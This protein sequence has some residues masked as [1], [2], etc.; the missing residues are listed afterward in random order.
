MKER[1]A[2]CNRVRGLLAEYGL[3]L[4]KGV[5]VLRRHLPVFLEDA[6]NGLNEL[7][8]RLL[9]EG[10]QQ[11]QDLDRHIDSYTQELER[12]AQQYDECR[13]LQTIPGY[14]PIVASAFH[15]AIGNGEAY[16]R[17]RDV[18]ASLGLVPRQHS[19]GGKDVLL[20]ISKRGDR[21]LRSLLVHGARSVVIQAGKKD[22]RLS[23]WINKIRAKRGFNRAVVALANK[24]ARIGWAVLAH[25]TVYQAA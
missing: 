11:L 17:G 18:S 7:F 16:R 2:L 9:A 15:S 1:T 20:G 4:P 19:S 6:E 25:K 10:Y 23:R 13:R 24:M 3:I 8:R 21:Y 12:Q 14:G 22:D 5:N